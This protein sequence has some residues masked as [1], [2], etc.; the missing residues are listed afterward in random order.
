[1]LQWG[2]T[3]PFAGAIFSTVALGHYAPAAVMETYSITAINSP[4]ASF[5]N[6]DSLMDTPL[7]GKIG[8]DAM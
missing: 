2:V 1:M 5:C 3:G 4:Y 6:P 8:T 7:A